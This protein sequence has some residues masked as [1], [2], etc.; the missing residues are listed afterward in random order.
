MERLT[1][2]STTDVGVLAKY[3]ALEQNNK[4]QA[5]YVW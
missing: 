3:M 1:G 4:V 5:E 2:K